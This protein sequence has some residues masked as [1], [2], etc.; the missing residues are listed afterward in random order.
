MNN[1]HIVPIPVFAMSV[2]ITTVLLLLLATTAVNSCLTSRDLPYLCSCPM[3][4]A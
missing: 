4:L 1:Y 2:Y 3:A